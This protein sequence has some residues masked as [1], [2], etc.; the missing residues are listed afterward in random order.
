[1]FNN[2]NKLTEGTPKIYQWNLFWWKIEEFDALNGLNVYKK[3]D[4]RSA[5]FILKLGRFNLR[6]RYSKLTKKWFWSVRV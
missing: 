4:P 2:L 5:G 6:V 1:M 3:T